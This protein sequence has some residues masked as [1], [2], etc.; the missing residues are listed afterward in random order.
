M[1]WFSLVFL[2]GNAL[3]VA[4]LSLL[5]HTLLQAPKPKLSRRW[6]NIPF[7]EFPD[8]LPFSRCLQAVLS[9]NSLHQKQPTC[10][11]FA[12]F[13]STSETQQ[14]CLWNKLHGK[15]KVKFLITNQVLEGKLQTT[16][17]T[18]SVLVIVRFLWGTEAKETNQQ[19]SSP[20][21]LS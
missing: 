14:V 18:S 19:C 7:S 12:G 10:Y 4:V 2:A 21:L 6:E 16:K 8:L 5:W 9:W 17:A 3:P 1:P 15:A 11:R 13:T 20:S